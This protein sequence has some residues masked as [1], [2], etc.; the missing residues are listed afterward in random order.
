MQSGSTFATG[1]RRWLGGVALS[2]AATCSALPAHAESQL[3][4]LYDFQFEDGTIMPELRIAYE[5][6]GTLSAARDNAIVLL[7]EA[8]ADHHAFDTWIGPGK[9][10]DT[11][12]YYVVAVDALGGGESAS[13]GDGK[14]QDF[15]RYTIR[16]MMAADQE[17]VTRILGLTRLRAIVGRSMGAFVGLEWAIHHPDMAKSLV[18][19]APSARSDANFQV[20]VD[21][22][23]GAIALDPDWDGG[24]YERNPVEGLRHAGMIYYPWSVSAA[25]L[26]RIGPTAL[27]RESAEVAKGFAAWDANALVLRLAACRG[28]DVAAPFDEQMPAALTPA[29]MPILLLDNAGDRL[30]DAAAT[31][32]LRAGLPHASYVEIPGDLGHRAVS[33]PPGTA[34]GDFIDRTV[35]AFIK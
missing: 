30:V 4:N 17:L 35:R 23:T 8:V 13:P 34:E 27:A 20:I 2:T 29:A 33:A 26:D 31:R 14:G 10:Y 5:A 24:H 1:L 19:L 28:H 18:L 22:M 12:K 3:V 15:P 25:H 7:H 32:R 9:L 11:N 16:D 21:L 6:Q